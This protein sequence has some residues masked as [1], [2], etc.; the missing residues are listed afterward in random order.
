MPNGNHFVWVHF[1]TL[2]DAQATICT[3]LVELHKSRSNGAEAQRLR[4]LLDRINITRNQL[5]SYLVPVDI[6]KQID[7]AGRIIPMPLP[8]IEESKELG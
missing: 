3:D 2:F 5:N 6:K 8:Q 4:I 7:A 1:N